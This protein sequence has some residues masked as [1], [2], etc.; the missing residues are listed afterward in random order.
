MKVQCEYCKRIYDTED[1]VCPG[2]GASSRQPAA[3]VRQSQA[4]PAHAPRPAKTRRRG[5]PAFLLLIL[6]LTAAVPL[7]AQLNR[8]DTPFS[9]SD[10][11]SA[12]GY[13][14]DELYAMLAE[15]PADFAAMRLLMELLYARG[16]S[17]EAGQVSLAIYRQDCEAPEEFRQTGALMQNNGENGDACRMFLAA[18]LLSGQGSDLELAD[19]CGLPADIFPEG[20]S[21]QALE[22]LFAKPMRQ[23]SWAEIGEV[24]YFAL[25]MKSIDISLADSTQLDAEEFAGTVS[26]FPFDSEQPADYS[27]LYGLTELALNGSVSENKLALHGLRSLRILRIPN[28]YDTGDLSLFGTLPRLEQLHIGGSGIVSLN[29][30]EGL[31]RLRALSLSSTKLDNLS[32]LATYRN[33]ESLSLIR[34]EL[35]T[36][37]NSLSAASHLKA[38]RVE[39]QDIMDFQFLRDFKQLEEL[40]LVNT[41]V[42]DL[43]FL[44]RLEALQSLTL[45]DNDA[46]LGVEGIGGLTGLKRLDI[47]CDKLA[48]VEEIGRLTGLTAL[49]LHGPYTLDMLAE[50]DKLEAL[51]IYNAVRLESIEPVKNL[52]SLRAFSISSFSGGSYYWDLSPLAS[53]PKLTRVDMPDCEFYGKSASLFSIE[54]LEYLNLTNSRME[55]GGGLSGLTN[56][57]TLKLNGFKALSNVR[58]YSD[59]FFTSIDYDDVEADRAAASMAGLSRLEVLE[60]AGSGLSD[61]SFASGLPSLRSLDVSDNYI[62]DAA[63]LG[64]APALRQVNLRGNPV[65]DWAVC[66]G[67]TGV[68]VIK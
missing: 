26:S 32:I 65:R 54:S 5:L 67:W 40:A 62:T 45:Y 63:S 64:G 6:L 34:N 56:I 27:Y 44:S 28:L 9:S 31:P 17:F 60:Y 48:G 50:L 23:I 13:T 68:H 14:V 37:V 12:K 59:G 24:K 4:V 38:L 19:S 53:L 8:T 42:K 29:G 39:R 35:L 7:V 33:I 20:P 61:A 21:V 57:K 11:P 1:G 43:F 25:H 49:K 66:E 51:E 18:Y 16:N 52:Q 55:I 22:F 15:N 41:K 2:C 46:L 10:S 30:L 58:V 3:E 47:A 36:S